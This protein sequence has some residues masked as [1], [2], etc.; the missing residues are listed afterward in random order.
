MFTPVDFN[1]K[2]FNLLS[3]EEVDSKETLL[4]KDFGVDMKDLKNP[5]HIF[6]DLSTTYSHN[7][8]NDRYSWVPS[9]ES[10]VNG[11]WRKE[12]QIV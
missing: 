2:N 1:K 10:G 5:Q 9:V 8:T 4:K 12:K 7:G 3:I 11:K 6:R